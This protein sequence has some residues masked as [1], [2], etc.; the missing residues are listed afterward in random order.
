MIRF[1]LIGLVILLILVLIH[2]YYKTKEGFES[3][4]GEIEKATDT[5]VSD[6]GSGVSSLGKDIQNI[7]T[8]SQPQQQTQQMQQQQQQ[9]Q[10]QQMQQQQPQSEIVISGPGFNAMSLQQK[11]ELLRDIQKLVKN[12]VIA[13]RQLTNLN[14]FYREKRQERR[15]REWDREQ[16]WKREQEL[17]KINQMNSDALQ[18]GKEYNNSECKKKCEGPCPRNKD[19]TCPPVP[20]MSEYIRKD[21]IPC[22]NCTLDY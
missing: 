7:V 12:E 14:D 9:M 19:G 5:V 20:D 16:E 15:E 6:I 22:W 17:N 2:S 8:S 1:I 3:L 21:Q 11:T 13:D 4:L 10:Q 18:Q